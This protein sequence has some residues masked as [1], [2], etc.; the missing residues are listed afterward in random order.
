MPVTKDL[1]PLYI[2]SLH[3][4]YRVQ[5]HESLFSACQPLLD[6]PESVCVIDKRVA[7]LHAESLAPL[8][9]SRPTL[10]LDA[11]ESTKTL[12]G[13]E[14]IIDWML[15]NGCTRSSTVIAIGGGIIQDAVTFT[16]NIYYR[17]VRFILL[18]TTLLSMCD[19]CIGAK[20][21]INHG[22]FKNQLGVLHA[23]HEVHV[24]T[25]FLDTLDDVDICSG[26]GEIIK[27]ALTENDTD[28]ET[29]FSAVNEG[30]TRCPELLTMIRR[31]LEI[32]QAVI[33]EDE[34]E[35]DLRRILNYGHT[36]GHALEA[37]TNHAVPHG[38]GVAWGITLINELSIQRGHPIEELAAQ[39]RDFITE[40]FSFELDEFPSAEKLIEMTRRDK[41]VSGGL[42]NLVLLRGAGDLIID[43]VPFDDDLLNGVRRFLDS[44]NGISRN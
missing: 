42:L 29:V 7:S 15:E 41:K 28:I 25:P 12:A 4:D 33:E 36:F 8:L 31:S 3:H 5:F 24:A 30:G 21:G 18:P 16:S 19:S 27:L 40:H 2:K 43:P 39:L 38:L 10:E 26:Y 13:V 11:L 22:S 32:K 1:A 35:T 17:G 23:P 37:L 20:C 34:Y 14:T 44:S 9:N 6:I